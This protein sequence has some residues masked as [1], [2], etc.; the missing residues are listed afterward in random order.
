LSKKADRELL[1]RLELEGPQKGLPSSLL[2]FYR[3]L[4]DIQFRAESA[5]GEVKPEP[6]SQTFNQRLSQGRPLLSFSEI[7]IGWSQLKDI[8]AEVVAVFAAYPELFGELPR[9]LREPGR[10]PSLPR[11]VA[12]A[13]FEND[14]LPPGIEF[15]NDREYLVLESIIQAT[16]RPFLGSKARALLPGVNQ[17]QWRRGYC[18]VC[19]G[20]PDIAYLNRDSGA[21]W[22]VCSRCDSEWIFQRLQCPYCDN[23]NPNELSYFTD[24]EGRYRLYVCEKCH[25]YLKTIDLRQAKS[26]VLIPLERLFTLTLDAQAREQG[27]SHRGA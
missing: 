1:K 24:D 20:S 13:W 8:F 17:E 5:I 15:D 12:R 14:R 16:I 27:Y 26:G 21:R 19:G 6:Q 4:L 7:G 10:P 23:Q 18:P 25:R 11:K 3:R 2:E 9:G 22:L